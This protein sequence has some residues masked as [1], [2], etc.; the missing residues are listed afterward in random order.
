MLHL[1]WPDLETIAMSLLATRETGPP[2]K[3]PL[4]SRVIIPSFVVAAVRKNYL[5]SSI[6]NRWFTDRLEVEKNCKK[7]IAK[8]KPRLHNT[9]LLCSYGMK[10]QSFPSRVLARLLL[11]LWS[12]PNSHWLP[13]W[14]P[15]LWQWQG[16]TYLYSSFPSSQTSGRINPRQC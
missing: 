13:T 16:T 2:P 4:S 1:S 3:L 10:R 8:V 5:N 9:A 14:L 7:K 11:A 12:T 6:S 15:Q